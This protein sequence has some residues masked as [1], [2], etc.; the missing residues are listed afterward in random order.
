MEF[1]YYIAVIADFATIIAFILGLLYFG[2]KSYS[3]GSITLGDNATVENMF[4]LDSAK[5]FQQQIRDI[6]TRTTK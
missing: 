4:V 6:E 5:N 1:L 2:T 3:R